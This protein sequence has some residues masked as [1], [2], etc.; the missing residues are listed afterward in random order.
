MTAVSAVIMCESGRPL[1]TAPRLSAPYGYFALFLDRFSGLGDLYHENALFEARVDLPGVGANGQAER[2]GERPVAAFGQVIVLFFLFS[3]VLWEGELRAAAAAALGVGGA[4]LSS[5]A[6]E[7]L[8]RWLL[9]YAMYR[10]RWFLR[11]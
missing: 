10:A 5:R 1:S 9:L 6:L 3:L 8:L 4:F 11:V 2:T 7:V